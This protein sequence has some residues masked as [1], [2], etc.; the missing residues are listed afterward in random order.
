MTTDNKSHLLLLK[1]YFMLFTRKS[2]FISYVKLAKAGKVFS[3]FPLNPI[4]PF[5][6]TFHRGCDKLA[7]TNIGFSDI[8]ERHCPHINDQSHHTR[9]NKAIIN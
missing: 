1:K 2:R 5:S 9:L 4:Y 3:V 6:E 7:G 8:P